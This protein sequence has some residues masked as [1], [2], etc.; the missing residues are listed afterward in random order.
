VVLEALHLTAVK[1]GSRAF[2]EQM[3]TDPDSFGPRIAAVL[4]GD[5]GEDR[6]RDVLRLD[7][8][9]WLELAQAATGDLYGGR[10]TTL[11]PPALVVHGRQDPR[12]EPGE[13]AAILAA[14][15]GARQSIQPAGRHSPH[16]ERATCEAVLADIAAF[17]REVSG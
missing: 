16:S 13:L 5:H 2:F 8:R 3:A 17:T 6:W 12:T 4:A 11:A 1:P 15:P 14:L 10:L 9:A 7:G